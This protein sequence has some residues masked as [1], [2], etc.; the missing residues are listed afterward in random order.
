MRTFLSLNENKQHNWSYNND[1]TNL[2][3]PAEKFGNHAKVDTIEGNRQFDRSIQD[4]K[5]LHE[6]SEP[7][8]SIQ[9]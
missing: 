3:I 5:K 9:N 1:T 8:V 2:N 7:L 6:K 4:L